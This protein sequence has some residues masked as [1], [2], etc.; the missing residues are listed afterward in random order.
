[1]PSITSHTQPTLLQE[2]IRWGYTLLLAVLSPVV[3]I[4]QT[5]QSIRGGSTYP[6]RG[7]QGLGR[8]PT[9]P[10]TGGLLIHCVSVGEVVAASGLIRRIQTLDPT[11]QICIST[12]TPTGAERVQQS[13]GT[14]VH[15]CYLPFDLP[16]AMQSMLNRIAPSRVVIMEV[17]LWPNLIHACWR[18]GIPVSVINA[19][20]TDRSR[21]SYWKLRGLFTPMLHKLQQVCCQGQRDYDN[22][23]KLGIEQQKLCLTNN[24]KFDLDIPDKADLSAKNIAKY[25]LQGRQ[26]LLAGSTHEPEEEVLLDAYSQLKKQHRGLLLV[27]VPR[28]P[29]RFDKVAELCEKRGLQTSRTSKGHHCHQA[30]DVLLADEMGLLTGLYA[31]ADIAFVGG[32][33]ASRG[34]HNALEPAAMAVPILMGPSQHNNPQICQVLHDAGALRQVENGQQIAHYTN[35]WLTHPADRMAS[36][37]AGLEVVKANRG[38]VDATLA[39]LF[40]TSDR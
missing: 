17:E 5:I 40:K 26:I 22:Y 18:K 6:R 27:L 35:Y 10:K 14:T 31:I 16:F 25:G 7:L 9:P 33:L 21:N 8:V 2:M 36:G 3:F 1:M 24:I 15:H 28:H 30:T 32:S 20:M 34:G 23:L 13:F 37:T 39:Q 12:T 4:S 38:A 19:R 29:Q 11:L